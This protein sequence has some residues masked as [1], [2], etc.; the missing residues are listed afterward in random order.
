MAKSSPI[1]GKEVKKDSISGIIDEI[2]KQSKG[3]KILIL[4]ELINID[5]KIFSKKIKSLINQSYNRIYHNNEI[6]K[7]NE[8]NVDE[9]INFDDLFLVIDRI[10]CND[11]DGVFK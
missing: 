6:I 5:K 3:D 9:I 4:S 8:I 10:V 11:S 7:L 2:K 1:S